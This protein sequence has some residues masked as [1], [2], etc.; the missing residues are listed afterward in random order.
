MQCLKCD[1]RDFDI[2]NTKFFPE[3]KGEALKIT[4]PAHTCKS[5][6]SKLLDANQLNQYRAAAAWAYLKKTHG[7]KSKRSAKNLNNLKGG[8]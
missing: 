8:I 1:S 3:V 4:V 2:K 7:K 5:C 6:G